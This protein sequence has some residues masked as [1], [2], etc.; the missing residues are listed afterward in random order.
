[1]TSSGRP[2]GR[3]IS[4]YEKRIEVVQKRLQEVPPD[5][6]AGRRYPKEIENYQRLAE[7][8]KLQK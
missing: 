3:R 7:R 5:S 6:P 1:M 8:L 2:P 4:D